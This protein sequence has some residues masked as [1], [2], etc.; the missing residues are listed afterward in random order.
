[1]ILLQ[2][3]PANLKF[4]SD[5]NYTYNF[6]KYAFMWAYSLL[7]VLYLV[8]D[9]EIYE[10]IGKIFNKEKNLVQL[11]K[12]KSSFILLTLNCTSISKAFVM[13]GLMNPK[14]FLIG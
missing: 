8:L 13:H 4:F 14:L 3:I 7:K 9:T 2:H 10:E 11:S 1:M 12:H 6:K 5:S